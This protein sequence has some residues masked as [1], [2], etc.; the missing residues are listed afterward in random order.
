MP[1]RDDLV[2]LLYV[3]YKPVATLTPSSALENALRSAVRFNEISDET[4]YRLSFAGKGT[5]GGSFGFMQGDLA[6]GQTVFRRLE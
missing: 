6:A 4:P 1:P 2:Q 5:S 3:L